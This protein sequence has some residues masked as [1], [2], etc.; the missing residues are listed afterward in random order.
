M[1]TILALSCSLHIY[2]RIRTRSY[3][4]VARFSSV[5]QCMNGYEVAIKLCVLDSFVTELL[6]LYSPYGVLRGGRGCCMFTLKIKYC[7]KYWKLYI[8][9]CTYLWPK[10]I[11]EIW[12]YQAYRQR[13]QILYEICEYRFCFFGCCMF[14]GFCIL[15]KYYKYPF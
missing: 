1:H 8:I 10:T 6:N 3:D 13:F 4:N 12:Y 14:C 5:W 2:V 15:F 11:D 7:K 9:T